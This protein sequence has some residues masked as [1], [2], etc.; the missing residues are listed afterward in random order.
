M[1][2]AASMAK[3]NVLRASISG[4]QS[5][6]SNKSNGMNLISTTEEKVLESSM[7][8]V[9]HLFLVGLI[10]MENQCHPGI[11]CIMIQQV[12]SQRK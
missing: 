3:V 5:T 8:I 11:A 7:W 6:A 1:E 9:I 10:Q 4:G 2:I 12:Q